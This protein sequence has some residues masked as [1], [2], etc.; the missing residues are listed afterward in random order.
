MLLPGSL[1]TAARWQELTARPESIDALADHVLSQAGVEPG[2]RAIVAGNSLGGLT[3]IAAGLR[4]PDRF[5][6]AISM[7]GS[8]DGARTS[9]GLRCCG[10]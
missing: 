4:R 9:A 5:G 3:A 6:Y 2:T 7:S 1:D 8:I 10:G